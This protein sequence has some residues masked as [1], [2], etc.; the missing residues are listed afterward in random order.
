MG[1]VNFVLV[2]IGDVFIAA[3]V[4]VYFYKLGYR[5]G[6]NKLNVFLQGMGRVEREQEIRQQRYVAWR[7]KNGI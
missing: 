5:R 2:L 4:A 6:S 1:K 7:K 3:G